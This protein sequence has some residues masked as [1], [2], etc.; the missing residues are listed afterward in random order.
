MYNTQKLPHEG[1]DASGEIHW[2]KFH[3][4]EVSNGH[5]VLC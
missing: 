3:I 5:H 1:F 4:V 2:G